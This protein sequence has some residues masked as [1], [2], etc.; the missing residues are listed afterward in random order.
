[1]PEMPEK[2]FTGACVAPRR[3]GVLLPGGLP[4]DVQELCEPHGAGEQAHLPLQQVHPV[5]GH[6]PEVCPLGVLPA[7]ARRG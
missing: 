6:A 7:G 2:G 1:M 3:Q 5:L 4:D